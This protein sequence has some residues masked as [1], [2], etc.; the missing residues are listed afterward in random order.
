MNEEY[1]ALLQQ[2]TWTLVDPPAHAHIIGCQWIYKIKRHSDGSVARYKARLVAKGNQQEEGLDFYET[3]SP[4]VKQPTIRVA[5]SL[6]VHYHWPL[7]QL[8]VSNAFLHGTLEEEVYMQQPLGY[9]DPNHPYHVCKLQKAL[10]G[11]RQAPRAWYSTFSEFLLASGFANSKADTS[12]FI[13]STESIITL[14]LVYVDDLIIT[15]NNESQVAQLGSKF[16]MKD[17]GSLSFFLGIEVT[18]TQ[19]GLV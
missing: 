3:F 9:R 11:L 18:Y 4:V 8:D 14:V 19:S 12:L 17:L 6:A 16:A 15:G 13:Y 2:G 1:Q 10:Y 7:R 5:L